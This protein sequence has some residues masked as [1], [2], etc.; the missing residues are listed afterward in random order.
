MQFCRVKTGENPNF[1]NDRIDGYHHQNMLAF[2]VT[3]INYNV[4][5]TLCKK[6]KE[7]SA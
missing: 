5:I 2:R 1:Q 4:F 6:K 7:G 3:S